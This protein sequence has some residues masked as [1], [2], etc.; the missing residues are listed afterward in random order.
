MATW[1]LFDSEN[2]RAVLYDSCVERPFGPGFHEDSDSGFAA[3]SFVRFAS[4]TAGSSPLSSVPTDVLDALHDAWDALTHCSGCRRPDFGDD[5]Q[6]DGG[7]EADHETTCDT[8]ADLV[9]LDDHDFKI[10]MDET[11]LPRVCPNCRAVHVTL[12]GGAR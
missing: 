3:D 7:I 12:K 6:S 11:R 1:T 10:V 5:V 2:E 4:G 8:F 9:E